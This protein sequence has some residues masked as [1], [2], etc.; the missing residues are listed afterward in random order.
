MK[1]R[2]SFFP[3]GPLSHF[4]ALLGMMFLLGSASSALAQDGPQRQEAVLIQESNGFPGAEQSSDDLSLQRVT[5]RQ[6]ELRLLDERHMWAMFVD[7]SDEKVRETWSV[8]DRQYVERD[9]AYYDDYR[10]RRERKH[11]QLANAFQ[12]GMENAQNQ[13]AR[14]QLRQ[15]FQQMG[16]DPDQPGRLVA[17]LERPGETEQVTILVDR[18]PTEVTIER[19]LIRE[20]QADHVAFDLWTTEDVALPVDVLA[21]YRTLGTFGPAVDARLEQVPGTLIRCTARLDLGDDMSSKTFVSTVLEVRMQERVRAPDVRVPSDWTLVDPE[22]LEAQANQGR[23]MRCAICGGEVNQEAADAYR[24][25][26]PTTSLRV[27]ADS[28]EHRAEILGQAARAQGDGSLPALARR[29]LDAGAA[30]EGQ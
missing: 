6:G 5:I 11:Q 8:R 18:V 2:R 24:W 28:S 3:A 25:N 10:A 9:F 29:W 22:E 23:T 4:G 27:Y 13:A 30:D 14:G 17:H 19:Y 15:A 7:M 12:Q 16:G 20:N 1:R 26:H 21:F